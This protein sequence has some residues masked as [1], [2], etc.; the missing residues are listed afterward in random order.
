MERNDV[1]SEINILICY[2]HE[3]E[4]RMQN[5]GAT[6][7][8]T[9]T[10]ISRTLREKITPRSRVARKPRRRKIS[11]EQCSPARS[12][13]EFVA[14]VA[15]VER[16]GRAGAGSGGGGRTRRRARAAAGEAARRARPAGRR[17]VAGGTRGGG[18]SQA[19]RRWPGRVAA[20]AGRVPVLLA[21]RK[22]T[23]AGVEMG[24][25]GW[26][27]WWPPGGL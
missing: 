16:R 10:G 2:M 19:G 7:R 9:W 20:R 27:G 18:S 6:N 3:S 22:T 26:A 11:P 17:G 12:S 8:G 24:W 14:D 23:G 21:G 1:L 25:A 15:G 5:Y 13:P 4:L